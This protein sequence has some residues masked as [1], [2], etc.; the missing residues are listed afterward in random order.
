MALDTKEM[1]D[2]LLGALK[3]RDDATATEIAVRQR[4]T[5]GSLS[6]Y[7]S[8]RDEYVTAYPDGRIVRGSAGT[9]GLGGGVGG[10]QIGR[11][12]QDA[13]WAPSSLDYAVDPRGAIRFSRAEAY[14]AQGMYPYLSPENALKEYATAKVK[15][16]IGT[17]YGYGYP[18]PYTTT[19]STELPAPAPVEKSPEEQMEDALDAAV[20]AARKAV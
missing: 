12:A 7:D 20:R 10:G 19:V 17:D 1:R 15:A 9:W 6:S 18:Q 11:P 4:M 8:L 14:M 5:D 3:E 16:L 13:L 2:I